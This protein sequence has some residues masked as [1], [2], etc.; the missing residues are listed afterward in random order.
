MKAPYNALLPDGLIAKEAKV[1]EGYKAYAGVT[2]QFKGFGTTT[3][4]LFSDNGLRRQLDIP[5]DQII[6]EKKIGE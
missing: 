2:V 4:I 1:P 3:V 5:N 6:V